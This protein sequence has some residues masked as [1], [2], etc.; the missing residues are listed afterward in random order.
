V[1][2]DREAMYSGDSLVIGYNSVL[3]EDKVKIMEHH[4]GNR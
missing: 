4:G 1:E 3:G 2:D